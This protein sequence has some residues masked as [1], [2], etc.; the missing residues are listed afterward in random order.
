MPFQLHPNLIVRS[1]ERLRPIVPEGKKTGE[2]TSALFYFL[3]ADACLKELGL[4]L[5]NLD[6]ENHKGEVNRDKITLQFAKL[7]LLSNTAAGEIRHVSELG[8]VEVG[9]TD[10]VKRISSNFLTV[11]LKK[12][13]LSREPDYYP[14]RPTA[15]LLSMGGAAT[16]QKWGIKKH[17]S[18]DTNLPR[19]LTELRTNTPFTDLAVFVSRNERYDQCPDTLE[20]ALIFALEAKFTKTLAAWWVGRIELESKLFQPPK[21]VFT[22]KPYR[23]LDGLGERRASVSQSVDELHKRIAYLERLLDKAAIDHE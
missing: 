9:G 22:D 21:E 5:L 8:S 11:S 1:F 13:T 2:R 6:P 19:F 12:A 14:K 23:P 20:E 16:G 18:W 3:A 15:P 4:D 7:S 17:E 10:P